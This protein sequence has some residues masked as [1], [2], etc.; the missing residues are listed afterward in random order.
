MLPGLTEDEVQRL[1]HA[2]APLHLPV[3]VEQ[4]YRWRGGGEAGIF[5]GWRLRPV[6][7][8]LARRALAEDLEEPPAWLQLFD[9]QIL[10]FT[11]LGLDATGPRERSVWYGHTHDTSVARLVDS[12]SDLIQV[13]CDA[14]ELGVVEQVGDSLRLEGAPFDD[15][16]WDRFRLA[17]CPT[18]F[19][20]PNPPRG[21][22]LSRF[23]DPEWPPEWLDSFDLASSG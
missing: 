22:Y 2:L 17:R 11:T 15:P 20:Y 19:Q 1:K 21:T 14:L 4:L 6:D 7:D 10:G 12:I 5:G 8:L 16:A 23:R 9:D 13:C 18:A 3:E